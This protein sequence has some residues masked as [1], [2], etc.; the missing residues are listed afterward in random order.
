VKVVKKISHINVYA[1]DQ[2]ATIGPL[3]PQ[4]SILMQAK[5]PSTRP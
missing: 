2:V 5:I 1:S 3:V 4:I